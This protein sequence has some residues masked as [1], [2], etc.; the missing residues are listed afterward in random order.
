MRK[1]INAL[2]IAFGQILNNK[3]RSLLSVFA[4]SIGVLVFLFVFSAL[5]YA[6]ETKAKQLAVAG[7]NVF[8]ISM[9]N[10]N[11]ARITMKDI[12][13][14]EQK[15]PELNFI[16][17][18]SE[19][20]GVK[21]IFN[22][23]Y[24]ETKLIGITPN[25][26][27]FD[28]VYTNLKGRFI[29]WD[30]IKNRHKVAVFVK[31]PAKNKGKIKRNGFMSYSWGRYKEDA[32]DW[33]E[34]QDPIGEKIKI[35]RDTYTIV[36]TIEAPLYNEDNRVEQYETDFFIPLSA[37]MD[38]FY[39]NYL[40]ITASFKDKRT[41]PNLKKRIL[42][43]LENKRKSKKDDDEEYRNSLI[44]TYEDMIAN[45][46]KSMNESIKLIS[47]LG[48]IAL[49]SGGIGIMNVIL[50]TIFARIKEIGTR[51]ALGASKTDIFMQFSAESI[52]LSL[53]GAF[54][55]LILSYF[56]I[57]Y[58]GEVINMKTSFSLLAVI[59]AFGMAIITGFIF[60]IYP[61]LKAANMDPVEA[62]KIE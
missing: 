21:A 56:L 51:R 50:A 53:L 38:S 31:N 20:T 22:N 43:F 28:W 32:V 13:E 19:L 62:L 44:N 49:I 1:I 40:L 42:R 11:Y 39:N 59:L 48:L 60:S 6:K 14:M 8:I 37:Y 18:R 46:L 17:P 29:S 61:A 16:A 10:E 36:G 7:E 35:F 9:Y 57:D 24:Y 33:H 34:K 55:G 3:I 25:H 2:N 30:D 12:E 27:K 5:N 15:F 47:I 58:M 23:K 26:M 4:I 45:R 41:F 54:M 52:I